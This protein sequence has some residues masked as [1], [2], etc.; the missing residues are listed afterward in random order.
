MSEYRIGFLD[1]NENDKH[2]FGDFVDK[3]FPGYEYIELTP[4]ENMELMTEHIW[5]QCL[6][7]LIIDYKLYARFNGAEVYDAVIHSRRDFPTIILTSH[8][9]DAVEQS[10]EPRHVY[11]KS[12]IFDASRDENDRKLLAKKINLITEKYREKINNYEAEH[13]KLSQ[14]GELSE[15]EHTRLMKIDNYLD[16]NYGR[17]DRLQ[18]PE[19][20]T[21]EAHTRQLR[22]LIEKTDQL[23]NKYDGK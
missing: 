23:L 10:N 21:A 13:R 16:A 20:Y 22:E 5:E 6:D 12:V 7:C 4:E 14:K 2:T 3:H 18:I 1:E 8:P 17:G 9:D 15:Q 19:A 11:A